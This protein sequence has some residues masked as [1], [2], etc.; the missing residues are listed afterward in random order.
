MKKPRID[1]VTGCAHITNF[2]SYKHF[3]ICSNCM[4]EMPKEIYEEQ[5]NFCWR[6][7]IMFDHM[8]DD[9]NSEEQR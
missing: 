5:L 6:C 2:D 9:P 8:D 4:A 3:R 7:G 1:D